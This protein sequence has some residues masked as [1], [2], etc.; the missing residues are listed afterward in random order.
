MAPEQAKR[1]SKKICADRIGAWGSRE[2]CCRPRIMGRREAERIDRAVVYGEQTPSQKARFRPNRRV[3]QALLRPRSGGRFS[4]RREAVFSRQALGV[5]RR[6]LLLPDG[7]RRAWPQRL[8][9]VANEEQR[10]LSRNELQL[11]KTACCALESTSAAFVKIAISRLARGGALRS[12]V[13][14]S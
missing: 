7:L 9:L 8:P 5:I 3:V 4:D 11:A 1:E 12:P 10:P 13:Y 14:A 6:R 2:R